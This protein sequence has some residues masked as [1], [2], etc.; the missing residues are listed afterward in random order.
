M[1]KNHEDLI[2]GE[3]RIRDMDGFVGTVVYVGNVASAKNPDELYCGVVW[4][5]ETRGKH[6]GSVL[7]RKTNR[8]VRHFHCKGVVLTH[9]VPGITTSGS[10][11]R[12]YSKKKWMIDTG[13]TLDYALL[14]QRYVDLDAPLVA[15]NNILPY[16]VKTTSGK[17]K[18]IEFLG[19]MN[20]R[21]KQ[22]LR[23]LTKI[24]LRG[25]GI[26]YVCPTLLLQQQQQQQQQRQSK[27]ELPETKSKEE[28]VILFEKIHTVDVAGNLFSSWTEALRILHLFPSL[29]DLSIASNRLKDF[30]KG[31]D[32]NMI[33][34]NALTVDTTY[35]FHNNLR[36]ERMREINVNKCSIRSFQT[37]LTLDKICPNLEK[38]CVAY[39]DLS[40]IETIVGEAGASSTN[41]GGHAHDN[42]DSSQTDSNNSENGHK[43]NN[44]TQLSGFR[45]LKFLDCCHCNL[46]DW[47]TQVRKFRSIPNLETLLLC[48]NPIPSISYSK[49]EEQEGETKEF[50][51]LKAIEIT[52]TK[53]SSWISVDTLAT[54]PS[55]EYV[56]FKNNP[57]SASIGTAEARST[58]IARLPQISI[59][60]GSTITERER[61][62]S[63]RRY[64]SNIAREILLATTQIRLEHN[65][66][67]DRYN[68]ASPSHRPRSISPLSQEEAMEEKKQLILSQNPMFGHLMAK[69]KDSMI[70]SQAS[71]TRSNTTGAISQNAVNITIRSMASNSCTQAP[72]KKHLPCNLKVGRLK[73]IC[74]KA[75]G[76]DYDSQILRFKPQDDPFPILLNDDDNTLSYYSINDGAE[77]LIYEMDEEEQKHQS[78]KN[79]KIYEERLKAQESRATSLQKVQKDE[80]RAHTVGAEQAAERTS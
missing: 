56:R 38:L 51:T 72:I 5:D 2:P 74:A 24:C 67:L 21:A 25:M 29:I 20:L 65:N 11:L 52:G 12:L 14:K 13:V 40:D 8:I 9:S 80:F 6:D 23:N 62:E 15:P 64:V 16:T 33:M 71:S 22:Q 37:I 17:E 39:S 50:A 10:F 3:T 63:E 77:V 60:N 18:P 70:V 46:S 4:D 48:D 35:S 75:F 73:L 66:I 57:V 58:I 27:E 61:I 26:S 41:N 44:D 78:L 1:I 68:T 43:C 32:I 59:L 28:D 49:S 55:L 42:H 7:C 69:H 79:S 34:K 45:H 76:L 47:T 31:H 53:M 19:E 30:P 54:F 36:F